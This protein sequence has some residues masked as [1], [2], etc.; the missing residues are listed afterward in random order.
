MKRRGRIGAVGLAAIA[1]LVVLISSGCG[2][3]GVETAS[4][5]DATKGGK[6]FAQ[7][8]GSCHTLKAAGTQGTIGPNL[9]YSFAGS[10]EEGYA[11]STIENLVLDQIR[12]GSVSPPLAPYKTGKEFN[13][14]KCIGDK[15][16][17]NPCLAPGMPANIVMGQDALDVAAYVARCVSTNADAGCASSVDLASLT[18]GADIF[19]LGP[20][21]GCH[22]LADA[23]TSGTTGP[24]LDQLGGLTVSRV[25]D[26]VIH[27][28]GPMPA[29]K[30][31]LTDAQIQAVAEYVASVAGKK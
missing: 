17:Q 24:N 1:V 12:L 28:G 22:T 7:D 25:A 11:S 9:D 2:Y 4:E 26:Q 19:K 3:G 10:L 31:T 29:Y 21:G 6:L 5:G 18:T 8:C 27:G 20:C 23:G 13:S 14:K 15:T 16:P 30:G